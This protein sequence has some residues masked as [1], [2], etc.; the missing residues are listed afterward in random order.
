[1]IVSE[2]KSLVGENCSEYDS[3]NI[4]SKSSMT[5]LAQSCISC[6]SY[7]NGRCT[8]DLFNKIYEALKVN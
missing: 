8:K 5:N 2:A 7:V 6:S 4:L 3:K 1:M